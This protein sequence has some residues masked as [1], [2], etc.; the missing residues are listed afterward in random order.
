MR[1]GADRPKQF[2]MK[3]IGAR[4]HLACFRPHALGISSIHMS[5]LSM[6]IAAAAR[7]AVSGT[8]GVGRRPENTA[9]AAILHAVFSV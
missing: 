5:K 8:Y 6:D 3:V 9:P 2:A 1:R 4:E 7:E